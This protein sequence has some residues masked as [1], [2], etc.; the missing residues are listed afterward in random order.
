M[1]GERVYLRGKYNL[2]VLSHKIR[3][4]LLLG[5]KAM[6]NL[7]SVLKSKDITLLTKVHTVKAMV[8]PLV[9]YGCESWITKKAEHQRIDA[10]KLD[11]TEIKPINPKGS[12]PWK[13]H[14][15][16]WI[17]WPSNENSWLT[18]KD[19]DAGKDWRHKR[20]KE[21]EMVGLHHWFNGHKLGQT[22]GAGER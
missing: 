10:F 11:N 5:W 4:W 3:R 12:Q 8:F 17:L 19:P 16:N 13:D 2:V 22:L 1:R 14:C 15:C 20:V 21:D 6:T 7:D 9:R 18:G